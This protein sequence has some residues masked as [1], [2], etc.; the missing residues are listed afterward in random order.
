ML[1]HRFS[2]YTPP[3]DSEKSDFERLLKVF[4][5][6]VLITAGNVGEALQ[7]LTEVDKQYG[8]SNDQY[9]IG[10]FIEDLKKNGYISDA[11]PDGEFKLKAKG[12]QNLRQ[13][14]LEEIFGKLKKS[15][16]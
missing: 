12:E 2:K 1:G 10:D 11:G 4:M 9:G 7:W 5:Q 16:G 15:K 13:S 6:L 3:P 14:A 8:L